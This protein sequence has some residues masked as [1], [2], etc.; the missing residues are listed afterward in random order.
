[1]G[2]INNIWI[3]SIHLRRYINIRIL[4]Q[5]ICSFIGKHDT[6]KRW[7]YIHK[8][9]MYSILLLMQ[10]LK[11]YVKSMYLAFPVHKVSLLICLTFSHD[12]NVVV[13]CQQPNSSG[14]GSVRCEPCLYDRKVLQDTTAPDEGEPTLFRSLGQVWDVNTH[15]HTHTH[16]HLHRHTHTPIH[17]HM[18]TFT[19]ECCLRGWSWGVIGLGCIFWVVYKGLLN[20][21]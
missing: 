2:K 20:Y 10:Y 14:G 17:T 6:N 4:Q 12:S 11:Y 16:T 9:F 13:F 1:M 18:F 8:S 21:V 3:F 7:N 19:R 5:R 15:I